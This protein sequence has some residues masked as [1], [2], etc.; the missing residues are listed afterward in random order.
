MKSDAQL[1][2]EINSALNSYGNTD[3]LPPALRS[4]CRELLT[5]KSYTLR[6]NIKT[7]LRLMKEYADAYRLVA[8]ILEALRLVNRFDPDALIVPRFDDGEDDATDL[9]SKAKPESFN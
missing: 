7:A 4:F 9:A 2:D 5:D 8:P 3:L 6:S 1:L